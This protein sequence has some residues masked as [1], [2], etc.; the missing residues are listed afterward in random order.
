M[1]KYILTIIF[2][3][4]SIYIPT[5]ASDEEWNA[6][7]T[8][9]T[10]YKWLTYSIFVTTTYNSNLNNIDFNDYLALIKSE[11]DGNPKAISPVG[12]R[13][14]GQVMPC[15]WESDLNLLYSIYLNIK[16]GTKI[17]K[18][19]LILA[20]G[21]KKEALRYYNAGP[22]SNKEKYK[23]YKTYCD[24]IINNSNTTKNLQVAKVEI[25]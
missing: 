10:Q 24:V 23:N 19:C 20:K 1:I 25:K 3:S 2:F 21:N 18:D 13:G 16:L 11:S 9:K 17:Y 5:I 14:L 8:Y 22:Y 6:F 12:A 7:D 4:A 15:H